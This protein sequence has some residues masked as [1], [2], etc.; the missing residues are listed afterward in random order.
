MNSEKASTERK[1]WKQQTTWNRIHPYL[2]WKAQNFQWKL[3]N[4]SF[5][6]LFWEFHQTCFNLWPS[7]CT[8]MKVYLS[9][10]HVCLSTQHWSHM[11]LLYR[12]TEKGLVWMDGWMGKVGKWILF[13]GCYMFCSGMTKYGGVWCMQYGCKVNNTGCETDDNANHMQ[14]HPGNFFSSRSWWR[15]PGIDP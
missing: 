9:V 4:L 10:L 12:R 3:T 11:I 1:K 7:A 14:F 13:H 15:F 6:T 2:L 5:T 8:L